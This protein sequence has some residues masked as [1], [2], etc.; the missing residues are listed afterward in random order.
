MKMKTKGYIRNI[1]INAEYFYNKLIQ[2]QDDVEDV[3]RTVRN[4]R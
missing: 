4:S 2:N 1:L 3:L